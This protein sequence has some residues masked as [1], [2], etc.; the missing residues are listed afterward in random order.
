MYEVSQILNFILYRNSVIER[1]RNERTIFKPLIEKIA[2]YEID[3]GLQKHT[4]HRKI[5]NWKMTVRIFHIKK[6]LWK[7]ENALKFVKNPELCERIE[8]IFPNVNLES[9]LKVVMISAFL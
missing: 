5:D 9:V 7:S 8:K 6:E 2:L 4:L 1:K 3:P